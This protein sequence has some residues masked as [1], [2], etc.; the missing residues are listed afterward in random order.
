MSVLCSFCQS[1]FSC[2]TAETQYREFETN[3]SRKG[4]TRPQSQFPHSCVCVRFIY[5]HDRSAYSAAGKYVNWS[6]D[7]INR[8]QTRECG[9]WDCGRAIPLLG[10]HKWN[11]RRSVSC[12]HLS[13]L[14]WSARADFLWRGRGEGGRAQTG[15]WP[16]WFSNRSASR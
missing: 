5:S 14:I 10:I 2:C 9:N 7:Y 6:W 16:L 11:F 15:L 3:I 1:V 13:A 8:S 4:I 12:P